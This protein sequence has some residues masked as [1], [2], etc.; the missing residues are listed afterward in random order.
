MILAAPRVSPL[1]RLASAP[2]VAGCF[3]GEDLPT[4]E[5]Q[6]AIDRLNGRGVILVDDAE[7][8]RSCDADALL[9]SVLR[10]SSGHGLGIVVA[11]D[12]DDVCGGF[13]GWQVEA[14]KA[15]RGLLLSPQ[16][17][18]DSDLV[19]VPLQRSQVGAPVQPGRGLLHLGDG[20]LHTVQVPLT[21]L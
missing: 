10:R 9:L 20:T 4:D 14:K 6:A 8:L 12:A 1:R 5:L 7:L 15:R 18:T 3:G 16:N 21:T 19:G 17:V 11:G 13:S 2:G